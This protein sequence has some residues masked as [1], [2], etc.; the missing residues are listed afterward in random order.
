MISVDP[1]DFRVIRISNKDNLV[2]IWNTSDHGEFYETYP[3][4]FVVNVVSKDPAAPGKVDNNG[5]IEKRRLAAIIDFA[6][7]SMS[8]QASDQV[9]SG[10]YGQGTGVLSTLV[11]PLSNE[12]HKFHIPKKEAGAYDSIFVVTGTP[13]IP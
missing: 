3:G 13:Y 5:Q 6:L 8:D 2:S 9:T 11:V 10:P 7:A 4:I 1:R 12:I